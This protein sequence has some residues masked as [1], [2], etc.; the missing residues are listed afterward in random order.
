MPYNREE[1]A[2]KGPVFEVIFL[3]MYLSPLEGAKP[4]REGDRHSPY[5][6][7]TPWSK[8]GYLTILYFL[9]KF[10]FLWFQSLLEC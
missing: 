5:Y 2:L 9:E 7:N 1:G 8:L 4:P 3:N 6:A 10:G